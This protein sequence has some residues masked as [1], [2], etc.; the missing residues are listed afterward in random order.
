MEL[1]EAASEVIT[2]M[3]TECSPIM[4]AKIHS[5]EHRAG[6]TTLLI[7]SPTHHLGNNPGN[8]GIVFEKSF[9]LD[10]A[11]RIATL[12]FDIV[13]PWGPNLESPPEVYMNDLFAGSLGPFFPP[14]DLT[15][16]EWVTNADGSHDYNKGFHVSLPVT[17]LLVEGENLFRIQNG[18]PDD[19]YYFEGVKL[20]ILPDPDTVPLEA[21]S[22]MAP[23]ADESARL[24]GH[25]HSINHRNHRVL[26]EIRGEAGRS[27][28]LEGSTNLVD[29]NPICVVQPDGDGNCGYED[30]LT[31]S[32]T[33]RFYR[34]VPIK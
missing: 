8:E 20:L 15:Q 25:I 28:I 9:F 34:V 5:A 3:E 32:Q 31:P 16:D 13:E 21:F 7:E 30:V 27:Y 33:C 6:T 10:E 2:V 24:A 11:G 4:A 12:E 22:S 29:W 19:D 14:L 18:R 17:S 26:L 23:V 1:M